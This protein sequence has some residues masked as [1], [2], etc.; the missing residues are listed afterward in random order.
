MHPLGWG[1]L[2][3]FAALV[4][5]RILFIGFIYGR[6]AYFRLPAIKSSEPVSVLL[7][8]RNEEENLKNNLPSLLASESAEFEVIA[9]DDFSSDNSFIVLGALKKQFKN[10]RVSSISQDTRYAEKLARN[11]ALKAAGNSWVIFIPPSANSFSANWLSTISSRLNG[12]FEVAVG[13]TNIVPASG[14]LNLFFR[15]EFFLQQLTSFGFI[16]NGMPYVVSEDNVAFKKQKYFETGGYG[17]K[18]AEPYAHLELLI[19]SFVKR[20]SAGLFLAG[21]LGLKLHKQVELKDFFEL[22][23]KEKRI[24]RHLSFWKRFVLF[25]NDLSALL[26]FPAGILAFVLLPDFLLVF[27][28]GFLL[29]ML[30]Y[31]VIIKKILYRLDERKL[32]LP[33]LLVALLRPY[34]KL[35]FRILHR[36]AERKKDGRKKNKSVG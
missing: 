23:I 12:Q 32:F 24:Q 18:L 7:A 14:L 3:F 35:F 11:V 26:V 16:A 30:S 22:L 13:Y 31:S 17:G 5:A 9:V 10:L 21:A 19:N 4:L 33:S 15:L 8:F 34:F 27:L 25:L 2:L 28:A 20:K 6:A 36:I 29:V 1:L